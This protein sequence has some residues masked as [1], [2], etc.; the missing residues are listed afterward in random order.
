MF[1]QALARK[2][3]AGILR[4]AMHYLAFLA[5]RLQGIAQRLQACLKRFDMRLTV[6]SIPHPK[7]F[8]SYKEGSLRLDYSVQDK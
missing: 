7:Q 1:E 2:L 8:Y 3:D 5:Q 6:R 4:L